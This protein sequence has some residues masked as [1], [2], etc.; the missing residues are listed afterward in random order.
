MEEKYVNE[1][2]ENKRLIEEL[3][4]LEIAPDGRIRQSSKYTPPERNLNGFNCPHCE[5]FS[6]QIWYLVYGATNENNVIPLPE[7]V[8]SKCER[9]HNYALWIKKDMIYPADSI[10][11]LPCDDMPANVKDDYLEARDIVNASPRG[12]SALLRLSLQ[13]LMPHIG[14]KGAN[15]DDDIRALVGK[16]LP[17]M[18]QQSL[19]SVRVIGNNAVHP[20]ELDLKDDIQTAKTLFDLVNLI[21]DY[22]ITK[23][24]S[25]KAIYERIPKD[26]KAAI[27]RKD[28]AQ[29]RTA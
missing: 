17:E 2:Q 26:A 8:A 9:C 11:P 23:P 21:V 14:E 3:D 4:S 19:D 22:T 6:H 7:L 12:A 24:E 20:G 16:G 25:V 1:E 10:A 5:A 27:A 15:L 28:N 18:I 13:K 29:R